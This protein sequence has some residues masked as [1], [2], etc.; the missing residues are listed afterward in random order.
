M[1]DTRHHHQLNGVTRLGIK[2][3]RMACWL[4]LQLAF[5]CRVKGHGKLRCEYTLLTN[6]TDHST[7]ALFTSQLFVL[8]ITFNNFTD[9]SFVLNIAFNSFTDQ[10]KLHSSQLPRNIGSLQV[11]QCRTSGI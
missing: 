9:P 5:L 7:S 4:S 6:L 11:A 3:L 10:M 2:A 1:S 8:N